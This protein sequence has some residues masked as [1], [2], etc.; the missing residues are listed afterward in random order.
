MVDQQVGKFNNSALIH[1]VSP[2]LQSQQMYIIRTINTACV[3]NIRHSWETALLRLIV[4]LQLLIDHF[5]IYC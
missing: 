2:P 4:T 1:L 3:I 5:F